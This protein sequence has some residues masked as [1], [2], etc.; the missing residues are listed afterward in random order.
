[1][2]KAHVEMDD[3]QVADTLVREFVVNQ[4]LGCEPEATITGFLTRLTKRE[5]QAP[6]LEVVNVIYNDPATVVLW[7]DGT[8][9][10]VTCSHGDVYDRQTGFLLC[11]AKKLFGNGGRFNDVIREHCPYGAFADRLAM[12]IDVK[13]RG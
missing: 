8:K 9:T 4:C 6:E 7:K 13:R 5:P 11:C 3:G 12:L 1:M 10:V 2:N